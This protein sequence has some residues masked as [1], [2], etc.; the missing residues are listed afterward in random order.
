MINPRATDSFESMGLI[1]YGHT[2]IGWRDR[3]MIG[4]TQRPNMVEVG[5]DNHTISRVVNTRQYRPSY[6]ALS[7]NTRYTVLGYRHDVFRG[8]NVIYAILRDVH[9]AD[10]QVRFTERFIQSLGD[11]PNRAVLIL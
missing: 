9:G 10:F 6:A 3:G 1:D 7:T 2:R 5:N 8:N 4:I 11:V